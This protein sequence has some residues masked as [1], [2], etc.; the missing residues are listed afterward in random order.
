M[1]LGTSEA[2][3]PLD[4]SFRPDLQALGGEQFQVFSFRDCRDAQTGAG[5]FRSGNDG[6]F[7]STFVVTKVAEKEQDAG[8]VG[9]ERET[10]GDTRCLL[11]ELS[12]YGYR[13]GDSYD[14]AR[15]VEPYEVLKWSHDALSP[16]GAGLQRDS[17]EGL[18]L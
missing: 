2:S 14:H 13:A 6:L 12:F 9:D 3:T 18:R 7:W 17:T 4:G 16:A 11:K 15:W 10:W 5:Q 1:G 8:E